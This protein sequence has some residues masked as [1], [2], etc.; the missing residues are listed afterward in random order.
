MPNDKERAT[1][2]M[3]KQLLS[4][5]VVLVHGW[6]VESD[7]DLKELQD[8]EEMARPAVTRRFL[9]DETKGLDVK[10][11][12][13]KYDGSFWSSRD[14]NDLAIDLCSKIDESWRELLNQKGAE[15]PI[16]LIGHSIGALLVRKA[17]L[18]GKGLAEPK[19]G[20]PN[21]GQLFPNLNLPQ[22]VNAVKGV[23]L[24]ASPNRGWDLSIGR[25]LKKRKEG[26][27]AL[28][29]K[30]FLAFRWWKFWAEVKWASRKGFLIRSCERGAPFIANLRLLGAR[31]GYDV[32]TFY[33]L[34]TQDK[35]VD[36][37]DYRDPFSSGGKNVFIR[38]I[39]NTHHKSVVILRPK[40]GETEDPKFA[41]RREAFLNAVTGNTTWSAWRND[42]LVREQKDLLVF[43]VHGVRTHTARW[44]SLMENKIQDWK[45]GSS[46][47]VKLHKYGFM[48]V[49]FFFWPPYHDAKV[50]Q[51]VNLVIEAIARGPSREIVL[52]GHSFGTYII[53]KALAEYPALNATRILLLAS[54]LPKDFGL[55]SLLLGWGKPDGSSY[56]QVTDS[57]R[58]D[59]MSKDIII[60]FT[61]PGLFGKLKSNTFGVS[62][63]V[64]FDDTGDKITTR[65][66][67]G[68]FQGWHFVP[69]QNS[70]MKSVAA[71]SWN[72]VPPEF[73]GKV[74]KEIPKILKREEP[75]WWASGL[76]T[77]Y[78][79]VWFLIIPLLH[80]AVVYLNLVPWKWGFVKFLWTLIWH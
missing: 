18:V 21:F 77:L 69:C 67:G 51:F 22:W 38:Q 47:E 37:T 25:W 55:N 23:V 28:D 36:V 75:A 8:L 31:Y 30:E 74:T 19:D 63:L 41:A 45:A 56:A 6:E 70:Y 78:W 15:I 40:N 27:P 68:R 44:M 13:Y 57:I 1:D 2:P 17:Y 42:T 80:D 49:P 62:G 9:L 26:N 35:I 11:L 12:K 64:G 29:P 65:W 46:C 71:F 24:L 76:Y 7:T 32:P 34:G 52:I 73:S 5:L 50:R 79:P 59:C 3:E 10:V 60:S 48:P 33:I 53:G 14:P 66:I 61:G 4:P 54:I 43:I 16:I 39:N 58:S 72:F 20:F